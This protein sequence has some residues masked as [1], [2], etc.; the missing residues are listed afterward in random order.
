MTV[1]DPHAPRPSLL[2]AL[3]EGRALLEA[4]ASILTKPLYKSFPRGDGHPVMVLPG[5]G[6]SDIATAPLRSFIRQRGYNVYPWR[7]GINLGNTREVRNELHE[8]IANIVQRH[9]QPISLVGWSLGGII[10]RHLAF[11]HPERIRSVIT[12][13]S[14]FYGAPDSTNITVLL[15]LARKFTGKDT[16]GSPK[17]SPQTHLEPAIAVPFSSVYSKTDGVVAW[18]TCL[19]REAPL[20]ENIHVPCSHIGFGFNPLVRYIIAERLA[21]P[22]GQWKPFEIEGIRK[23]VYA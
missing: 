5:F 18:Q 14:P 7:H 10:S 3:L 23:L 6:T 16:L 13:G 22:A 17:R 8:E 4:G 1:I 21:Q 11:R 2:L 15:N 20:R 19:E 12:L 9:G